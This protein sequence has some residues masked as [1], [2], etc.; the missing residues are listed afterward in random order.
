MGNLFLI[1]ED[2]S[3]YYWDEQ[4]GDRDVLWGRLVDV[5]NGRPKGDPFV[6]YRF[7]GP[8][9]LVDRHFQSHEIRN[10]AAVVTMLTQTSNIWLQKLPD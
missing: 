8:A 3:V 10:G 2:E 4:Q 7:H 6:A 1:G 9:R 5:S